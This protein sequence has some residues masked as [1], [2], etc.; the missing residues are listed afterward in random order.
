M[1]PQFSHDILSINIHFYRG[2]PGS[3]GEVS[4]Q[5]GP[6]AKSNGLGRGD[7]WENSWEIV[8]KYWK[9]PCKRRFSMG[10]IIELL[11]FKWGAELI[12]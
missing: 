6:G 2:F 12:Y 9:R 3:F 8:G 1:F 11:C 7:T 5:R 4:L 10:K